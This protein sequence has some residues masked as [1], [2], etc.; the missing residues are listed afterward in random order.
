MFLFCLNKARFLSKILAADPAAAVRT[1]VSDA[2][3]PRRAVDLGAARLVA[4]PERVRAAEPAAAV[5]RSSGHVALPDAAVERRAP[6]LVAAVRLVGAAEPA[7]AR[8]PAAGPHLG[9][10]LS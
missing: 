5:L 2:V 1:A 9:R 4:A 7:V 3:R 8:L 6:R 10:Q